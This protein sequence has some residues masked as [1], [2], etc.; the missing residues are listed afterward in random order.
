MVPEAGEA[1]DMKTSFSPDPMET[2]IL[3]IGGG[4]TGAAVAF[5]LARSAPS[6]SLRIA[7]VEPRSALG[8]GLAYSTDDPTHRINVPARRM[9]LDTSEPAHFADWLA[10]N[11]SPHGDAD[12][13]AL[14]GERFPARAVFGRYVAAHLAPLL[15]AGCVRH[16]R[17]RAV[18]ATAAEGGYRVVL[19]DGIAVRTS[20]LVLAASHPAPAIPEPLRAVAGRP[21]FYGDPYDRDALERIGPDESVLIVGTGLTMAD[22]V[23]SLSAR[24]HRGRILALSR[25]GL[26]SLGHSTEAV[27][28]FGE[29]ALYP[30]ETAGDLLR[31]VRRSVTEAAQFG[32]P[33]QAVLDRVRQQGPAIWQA[34]P[35]P[36]RLR[37]VRHLR[38]FW[39]IHRFRIAPQVEAALD[40][41]VADGTL[42]IAAARVIAACA[43]PAGGLEI[44]IRRRGGRDVERQRFDAVI[45]T[46]GPAHAEIVRT[47]PMIAGLADDGVVGLDPTGLGLWTSE[48]GRARRPG[49]GS[50]VDNLFVAGPLARGTFGELMG[51]PEVAAYA[52]F[53]AAQV[54]HRLAAHPPIAG[55][56]NRPQEPASLP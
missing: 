3:I 51:L 23:A 4:F 47:E 18:R 35:L 33:W 41:R 25:H 53:I 10:S 1:S 30:A 17:A 38:T 9:S 24:G 42:G 55:F 28:A 11:T 49:D 36:E 48:N 46:T 44:A 45:V 26:R 52:A 16:L 43:A 12:E 29:F 39:D 20:T 34:L 5:H 7:V 54:R 15:A 19:D 21:G 2:D 40:R 13:Y 31:R 56:A 22:I 37:L 14:G 32:V 27:D 50:V 6:P 8:A